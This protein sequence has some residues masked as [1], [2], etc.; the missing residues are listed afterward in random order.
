MHR[1][2]AQIDGP[3]APIGITLAQPHQDLSILEHL[4][5]PAGYHADRSSSE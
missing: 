1:H 4:E 2:L 3:R 5:A